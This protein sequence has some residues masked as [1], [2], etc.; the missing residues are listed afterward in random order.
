MSETNS[1]YHGANTD[2]KIARLSD[3]IHVSHAIADV[4]DWDAVGAEF[5]TRDGVF[6]IEQFSDDAEVRQRANERAEAANDGDVAAFITHLEGSMNIR[7][8]S[9]VEVNRQLN[10]IRRKATCLASEHVSFEMTERAV[11]KIAEL[12]AHLRMEYPDGLKSIASCAELIP[13][14]TLQEM[15]MYPSKADKNVLTELMDNV[16]VHSAAGIGVHVRLLKKIYQQPDG[17]L[18]LNVDDPYVKKMLDVIQKDEVVFNIAAIPERPKGTN[19]SDIAVFNKDVTAQATHLMGQIGL[20]TRDQDGKVDS[21]Y[22]KSALVRLRN[23]EV[24]STG[25]QKAVIDTFQLRNELYMTYEN[26]ARVGGPEEAKK[27]HDVFGIDQLWMYSPEELETLQL[28]ANRDQATIDHLNDG[29]VTVVFSNAMDDHNG[30]IVELANYRKESGR[31]LRFESTHVESIYRR[32]IFLKGLGIKPSTLVYETHGAP[33]AITEGGALLWAA[34]PASGLR[35]YDD[36]RSDRVM[37]DDADGLYRLVRDYMQPN[38]GIDSDDELIGKKQVIVSACSSDKQVLLADGSRTS[39][40]ERVARMV[41]YPSDKA[42]QNGHSKKDAL[43]ANVVFYGA[44]QDM[45]EQPLE[46]GRVGFVDQRKDGNRTVT[47]KRVIDE[48]SRIDRF[49]GTSRKHI[50]THAVRTRKGVP[51]R[52]VS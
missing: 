25:R 44:L 12:E 39:F 33:G 21:P 30:A 4:H 47:T 7:G 36:Q 9:E 17:E 18:G 28:L 14:T 6:D 15:Y 48:L 22:L 45:A 41:A 23:R 3:D 38:R 52:R 5:R 43:Q 13:D 49:L 2:P 11:D 19:P 29:D 31:T 27:L 24:E 35:E 51:V 16:S 26:L 32:M 34:K 10:N 1:S 40:L 20:T 50:S 8:V 42:M 37:S 46:N